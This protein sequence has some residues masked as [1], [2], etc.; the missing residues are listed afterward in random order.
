MV[1]NQRFQI[2]LLAVL[3]TLAA[4]FVSMSPK[5]ASGF[6]STY[7]VITDADGSKIIMAKPGSVAV[8]EPSTGKLLNVIPPSSMNVNAN[9]RN[10]GMH[11]QE[12][13]ML[14]KR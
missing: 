7:E 10:K 4:S 8:I 9:H 14:D 3:L 6:D 13:W 1:G 11:K 2:T 5:Q 12:R